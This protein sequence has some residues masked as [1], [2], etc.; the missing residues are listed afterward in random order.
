MP[1]PDEATLS[2]EGLGVVEFGESE[3]PTVTA[4]AST[5]GDPDEDT[6]WIGSAQSPFGLCG[7]NEYR[8]VRWGQLGMLFTNGPGGAGGA[9]AMY[10]YGDFTNATPG[11]PALATPEGITVTDT[12]SDVLNTY[13]DR[14]T[15]IAGSEVVAPYISVASTTGDDMIFQ[16]DG[17]ETSGSVV[18]IR[19]GYPCG[20]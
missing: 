15:F 10:G 11:V 18:G 6:A 19:A 4:V 16:I 12:S 14:A 7:G 1:E 5:L 2:Y 17:T 9:F 8:M 20:E 13:G 3:Q